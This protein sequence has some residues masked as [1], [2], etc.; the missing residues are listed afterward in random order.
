MMQKSVIVRIVE[1]VQM[2]LRML[3]FGDAAELIMKKSPGVLFL[4]LC[5]RQLAW[6]SSDVVPS[7]YADSY[8]DSHTSHE[9]LCFGLLQRQNPALLHSSTRETKSAYLTY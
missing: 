8:K 3:I 5:H 4:P 9:S 2:C 6:N 7:Q 1:C